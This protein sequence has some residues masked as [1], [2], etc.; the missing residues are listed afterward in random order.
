[1]KNKSKQ[2]PPRPLVVRTGVKAGGG[3]L[4]LNHNKRR[5]VVKTGVK[6]GGFPLNHNKRRVVVKTGL[7]AGG[8][9]ING[10]PIN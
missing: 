4:P 2:T 3:G 9:P 1:M 10:I 5:V 6:A 7:R 8:L